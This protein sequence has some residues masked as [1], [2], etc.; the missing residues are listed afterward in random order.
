MINE[1]MHICFAADDGYAPYMGLAILSILMHCAEG[2]TF[3]F[4]ILD[5]EISNH[6]KHAIESLNKKYSFEISWLKMDKTLFQG[7]DTRSS[8]WTISIFGRYL[9]PQL[10]SADKV[11]YLD[12]DIMARTSLIPLW[13]INLG[14][15]YLAGVPDYN[16]I[17]R[18]N[19]EERFKGQLSPDEYV[20][21]GVLL[22]NN[23]KWREENIFQKLLSFSQN[24]T[25]WLLWPDQDAINFICRER[26]IILPARWNVM[27]HL[28]KPDLFMDNPHYNSILQERDIAAI[29]HFHPWK[30]NFFIPHR[31]EYLTLMSQSP[32]AYLLPKDDPK[33]MG[34]LKWIALYLW[35]H[36]FCFLLP[37]FY[38]RWYYRGSKCLFIDY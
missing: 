37:K 23:K 10:I 15:N 1:Q 18:G 2:E 27:G 30:K 13:K 19:I 32:W 29:R 4:Y 16:V 28:Y 33:A 35:H 11:L 17:Y 21:S 26:K 5:N 6:N 14:Q 12:C 9:I 20:N 24:N 7:C 34:Y 31:E 25:S 22:I 36:P 3:H 38:K 8:N